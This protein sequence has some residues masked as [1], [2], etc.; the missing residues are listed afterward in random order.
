MGAWKCARL[1]EEIPAVSVGTRYGF[2]CTQP[3]LPRELFYHTKQFPDPGSYWSVNWLWYPGD[4]YQILIALFV[5]IL[6]FIVML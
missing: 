3:E 1:P 5:I 2:I 6:I 4:T